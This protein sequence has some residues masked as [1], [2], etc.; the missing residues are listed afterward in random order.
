MAA[1]SSRA[2]RRAR[3]GVVVAALTTAALLS[4][5]GRH[6]C[7]SQH[8]FVQPPPRNS[9]PVERSRANTQVK[10][11]SVTQQ[12]DAAYNPDW[13]KMEEH[14]IDDLK[15]AHP[16]TGWAAAATALYAFDM[17]RFF[18]LVKPAALEAMMAIVIYLGLYCS[19]YQ[20]VRDM[21]KHYQVSFYASCGWTFYALASLIHALSYGPDPLMSRGYAEALHGVGCTIYL[22]SC[23][24][25]YS[26]HWGRA[27]RHIQEG[28][29]RPWFAVGLGSLSLVHGLTVGHIWKMMEDPGWFD[30][31][32]KIYVDQWQWIADTRLAELYLTA[33]AL[34]LVILHLR[35]VLTGTA[36]SVWVFLGTVIVPTVA[37]FWET[38]SLNAVAWQHYW[39][40]G[41]KHFNDF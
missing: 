14:Q 28:R 10:M 26:Y 17:W 11:A 25:F 27:W 7:L 16:Q 39:M 8:A 36:N 21:D 40:V 23:A 12:I 18:G 35:G 34:F 33:A 15:W 5:A 29:F 41:P 19:R 31:V 22:G 24:Y 3:R 2:T 4:G 32:Q 38:T 1:R 6:R 30:T 13:L 9:A 20:E 37:L